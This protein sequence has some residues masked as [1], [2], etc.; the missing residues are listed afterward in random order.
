MQPSVGQ[1]GAR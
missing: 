1:F